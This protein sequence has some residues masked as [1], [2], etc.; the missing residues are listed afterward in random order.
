MNSGVLVSME[1]HTLSP[2]VVK[3]LSATPKGRT[4]LK[5]LELLIAAESGNLNKVIELINHGV[6]PNCD[7]PSNK[8]TP[9]N[10]A[11]RNGHADVVEYLLAHGAATYIRD[12][13]GD[14][15]LDVAKK[16][17]TPARERIIALLGAPVPIAR[18][19]VSSA[20]SS[21][22][23]TPS[24]KPVASTSSSAQSATIKKITESEEV[25]FLDAA[26][27]GKLA[28]VIELME[29]GI[30]PNLQNK[31]RKTA[32]MLAAQSGHFDIVIYLLAHGADPS[33]QDSKGNTA[34][35]IAKKI[36]NRE[37]IIALLSAPV[38]VL[39]TNSNQ[40]KTAST[41]STSSS[42]SSTQAAS[43]SSSSSASA[44]SSSASTSS[45]LIM[46]PM[47]IEKPANAPDGV[48]KNNVLYLDMNS[49]VPMIGGG[50]FGEIIDEQ[51]AVSK[52]VILAVATTK[53]NGIYNYH[54]Y[55]A[56]TTNYFYGNDFSRNR[57]KMPANQFPPDPT[58]RQ[59]IINEIRFFIV[60]DKSKP[61]E[62][63]GSDRDLFEG[64]EDQKEFLRN[65]LLANTEINPK[66]DA[67]YYLG[68]SYYTKS[69]PQI[70]ELYL[71]QAADKGNANAMNNLADLYQQQNKLDLAEKYYK[72]AADKGHVSAMNSLGKLYYSQNKLDLAQKYFKSAAD[73]GLKEAMFNL[74]RFYAKQNNLNMAEYNYMLAAEKG[75]IQAMVNVALLYENQGRLDLA[76]YYYKQAANEGNT[77]VLFRLGS[78]YENQNKLDLAEQSFKQALKILQSKPNPE[79]EAAIKERL[80]NLAKPKIVV[81]SPKTQEEKE[82]RA[83]P[84]AASATS[85]QPQPKNQGT[86]QKQE[87]KATAAY[88]NAQQKKLFWQGVERGDIGAVDLYLNN[89]GKPNTSNHEGLTALALAA[90]NGHQQIIARLIAA[91][92]DVNAPSKGGDRPI[93]FAIRSQQVST[94]QQL[95]NL[96]SK[97]DREALP[98]AVKLGNKELIEILEKGQA[99]RAKSSSN[100]TS[101]DM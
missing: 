6:N 78:L 62:Y 30:N 98:I 83:Q 15:A 68:I 17:D 41:S 88:S 16:S 55:E 53:V 9:L 73:K 29:L 89:G 39:E 99:T 20:S 24:N 23:Q 18:V 70:A 26:N 36:N 28:K 33:I 45:R 11:I 59:P 64:T 91:G 8:R 84:S 25:E 74:G 76:E 100:A 77:K 34:L 80:A 81:S 44:S 46:I 1:P 13:K 86:E 4:R 48:I 31:K 10:L 51:L 19:A 49:E 58:N 57:Y 54:F 96:G 5:E 75:V 94:V 72:Q 32:L 92:A 3:K 101:S 61:A 69:K 22:A 93:I 50:S 82:E 63:I 90:Q 7:R 42:S 95:I 27:S 47:G 21:P 85:G 60:Y 65:T 79:L 97:I 12:N 2:E 56:N 35:D 43:A 37:R 52:P 40:L 66:V 87:K 71:K 14:V 38:Q 67:M